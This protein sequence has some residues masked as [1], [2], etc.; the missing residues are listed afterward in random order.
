MDV[1][2][3]IEAQKYPILQK[4]VMDKDEFQ[5]RKALRIVRTQQFQDWYK[6]N[7]KG[8]FDQYL[9]FLQQRRLECVNSPQYQIIVLQNQLEDANREIDKLQENLDDKNEQ[10]ESLSESLNQY[11]IATF[12]SLILL[13]ACILF[14]KRAII[15]RHLKRLTTKHI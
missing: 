3:F 7:P 1:E 12:I 14:V 15:H 4:W 5:I 11:K 13:I 2:A 10:I 9:A 6:A 8:T